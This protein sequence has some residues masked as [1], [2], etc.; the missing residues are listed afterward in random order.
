MRLVEMGLL[1]RQDEPKDDKKIAE[2]D[3]EYESTLKSEIKERIESEIATKDEVEMFVNKADAEKIAEK[4]NEGD[5]ITPYQKK[6]LGW[7]KGIKEKSELGRPKAFYRR[8]DFGE[9]IYEDMLSKN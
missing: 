5:E 3:D 7:F 4:I 6:L 2:S 8:T 9:E 1:E